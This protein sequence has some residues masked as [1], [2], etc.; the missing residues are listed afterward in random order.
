MRTT[1]RREME[2]EAFPPD[3]N[4]LPNPN[5]QWLDETPSSS[6]IMINPVGRMLSAKTVRRL[7][8]ER[9]R[10]KKRKSAKV[11]R[12]RKGK[13]GRQTEKNIQ[14]LWRGILLFISFCCSV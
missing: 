5:L 14:V 7:T 1:D 2:P 10:S 11:S 3:E 12:K 13:T 9:T 6:P 4:T 8:F